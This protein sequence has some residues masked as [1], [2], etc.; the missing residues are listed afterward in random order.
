MNLQ[1]CHEIIFNSDLV[2]KNSNADEAGELQERRFMNSQS[3]SYSQGKMRHFTIN[4]AVN[5]P[6]SPMTLSSDQFHEVCIVM[7]M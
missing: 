7:M 2:E 5:T 3:A 1:N 4:S 6:N